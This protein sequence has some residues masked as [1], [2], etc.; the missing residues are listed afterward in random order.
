MATQFQKLSDYNPE[1]LPD[2]GAL[3]FAILVSGWNYE[4]TGQLK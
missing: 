4:I 3:R 2:A 1:Q